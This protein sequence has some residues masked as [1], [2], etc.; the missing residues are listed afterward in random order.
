MDCV[1]WVSRLTVGLTDK[2][3]TFLLKKILFLARN[4]TRFLGWLDIT[5]MA[6][7]FKK[8]KNKANRDKVSINTKI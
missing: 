5:R 4:L 7:M 6:G 8:K 3:D 2:L 1:S